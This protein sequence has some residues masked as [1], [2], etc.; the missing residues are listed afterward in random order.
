MSTNPRTWKKA[1]GRVAALFDARRQVLSG[2]SGRDDATRSDTT[3]PR[4]FIEAKYRERHAVRSLFDATKALA[5]KEG[6]T[7]VVA[8]VDKGRPGCLVCVHCD[9]LPAI[10]AEFTRANPELVERVVRSAGLGTA[11]DPTPPSDE[12]AA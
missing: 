9:D 8:L 6:K 11:P 1:E 10:A 2:S 12:A 5:R 4:L 7:P 3:H